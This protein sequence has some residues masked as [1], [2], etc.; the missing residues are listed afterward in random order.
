MVPV[1]A[2]HF[3][4]H[5]RVNFGIIDPL[6]PRN[7]SSTIPATTSRPGFRSTELITEK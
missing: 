2:F 7:I 6:L 3:R 4:G 5:D 1:F